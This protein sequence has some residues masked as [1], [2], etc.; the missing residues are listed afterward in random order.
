MI[1]IYRV[2]LAITCLLLSSSLFGQYQINDFNT[3]QTIDFNGFEA[4]GFTPTPSATQ[5]N[6]NDWEIIGMS[7][8]TLNFGGTETGG[9]FARGTS[10]GGVTTGGVYSF[11]VGSGNG[12]SL[13]V[14]P[15]GSDFTPGSITLR[16][17]NNTGSII[18]DLEIDYDVFILNDEDRSNSFNF[19]HSPDNLTF[20]QEA[21][22]NIVSPEIQDATPTWEVNNRNI[23]L[24]GVNI[25]DGDFYYLKWTGDDF[26]GTGGRD[27]FTLDNISITAFEVTTP[28]IAVSTN[29]LT[30]FVQP[31]GSPSPEQSFNVSGTNLG[32][33]IT[34][35]VS[36]GDYQIAEN[37]GGPYSNSITLP[38]TGGTV[39]GTDIY[40]RLNGGSPANPSNGE[41]QVSS[42]SANTEFINLEGAIIIPS[43]IVDFEG[44]GETKIGYALDTVNL[45]GLDWRMEEALIGTSAN[46]F[47]NGNRSARL[48][49]LNGSFIEMIEDKADGIGEVSFEYSIY[50]TD[51]DQQPWDVEYSLDQGQSWVN[52]G[53]V[54]ADA[55]V[56]SFNETIE[57]GGDVRLRVSLST[58]PGTSG[59]RRM[60]IDDIMIT[61]FIPDPT[62]SANPTALTG[63]LQ[64]VG[65]PSAEQTFE[66]EGDFL[67]DD[68]VV[69]VTSGDYE[70]AETSG[71]P[72][73]NSIT[74]NQTNGSIG[75][76]TLFVRLNG[77]APSNPENGEIT[78]ST[79]GTTDEFVQLEGVIQAAGSPSIN[80]STNS[81][82]G[83]EQILGT[84]S[85]EQTFEVSAQDLIDDLTLNLAGTEFEISTSSGAGF[86]Q[87]ITLTP[88]GGEITS[89]TIYVRL[90]GG[91]VNPNATDEITASSQDAVSQFLN[92]EGEIKPTPD[93]TTSTTSLSG[94]FQVVGTPSASLDF[95]V[96]G[97]N[98][99]DDI[100]VEVTSGDYEIAEAT[101]GPWVTSITLEQTNGEVNNE[102]I[103][104]RLNGTTAQNPAEGEI[105]LTSQNA[106]T[107]V[108]DL[109]GEIQESNDPEIT[110]TPLFLDGFIQ[111]LGIP[112]P[113]QSFEVEGSELS[114]D[115]ELSSTN[116][117]EI[118][119]DAAGPYQTALVLTETNGTVASTTIYVRLNGTT[120][121][122]PVLGEVNLTSTGAQSVVID[123]EGETIQGC[124]LDLDVTIDGATLTSQQETGV[125]YQWYNCSTFDWIPGGNEQSFEPSQNGS[126][127]VIL[128]QDANCVDTSGCV[129]V[130]T[131]S[132]EKFEEKLT[133]DVYPNPVDNVLNIVSDGSFIKNISIYTMEGKLVVSQNGEFSNTEKISTEN[134]NKGVYQ[135]V[136]KTEEFTAVKK[137]VK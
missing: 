10:T 51:G 96:N 79:A 87:S 81:L 137:V 32:D 40:V 118:S 124:N 91:A 122:D 108:I 121:Q 132:L 49:G 2:W 62:I 123:L 85:A 29:S 47:K 94:F 90:N 88:S 65:T 67:T 7:D 116:G 5:L 15:I 130:T 1:K 28:T 43:Y 42:P 113:E 34:I 128:T 127:A 110:A 106:Q 50:G 6:S 107:V 133:V 30:G 35:T 44:N 136:I 37:S 134:W 69:E 41:L 54:I 33:D 22:L 13:G 102:Q 77:T 16:I 17:E 71:G 89:T 4:D 135:V 61:D 80:L 18:E 117:Y 98:L 119:T 120:L 73:S 53:T 126:Y 20:S 101:G 63:F 109:T 26:S 39:N 104:V 24:S 9:D 115:I 84:P 36:A 58:A 105:T 93:I 92:L 86:D 103:F 14:Q 48:R 112:S 60:N 11:D 70:I 114:A 57:L 45:S 68:V 82:T 8:G 74:L 99:S 76:V 78:I 19:E 52:I 125:N 83:F 31:V 25:G 100:L 38:E 75:T 23:T 55:T 27:E 3:T 129:E 97:D 64:N 72:F 131:V 66:V 56:Q 46:D 21:S 12:Q 59:N 95:E 111:E